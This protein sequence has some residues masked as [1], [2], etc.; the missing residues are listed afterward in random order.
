MRRECIH[1]L[2]IF[3]AA[4]FFLWQGRTFSAPTDGFLSEEVDLEEIIAD[5]PGYFDIE[6]AR[7]SELSLLPCFTEESART[8]INFRDALGDGELFYQ[9]IEDI[10]GLSP[11]QYAVLNHLANTRMDS[12]TPQMSRSLRTGFHHQ[13]DD[14]MLSE[15]RY[16][17]RFRAGEGRKLA[18][19]FLGERDPFE[20][21]ALDLFSANL[22][23]NLEKARTRV[24]IGDYRWGFG[25]RLVLS[26][27]TRNYMN[28]PHIMATEP[29][30]AAN[31]S[32]EETH[33]L[34][35]I[36]IETVREHLSAQVCTS[37]RS[38][39]ATVDESGKA[40]SI[41]ESG[42][43][44]SGTARANLE[45]T[46]TVARLAFH[47][48][49]GVS[50]GVAG[51]ASGYSPPL[52]R[53]SG[54]RYLA[55]PEGSGFNYVSVDGALSRGMTV[56]FF[57]HAR[58]DQ[59]EHA[60]L[61]G[62][63]LHS[64][65]VRGCLAY[66][67]YTEGYWA[68]RSGGISSFGSTSNERGVYSAV[69]AELPFSSKL[70]ASMDLA[71]TLS[72]TYT[73]T[74]PVSRRRVS[75]VLRTRIRRKMAVKMVVRS[76]EDSGGL[77]NHRWNTRTEITRDSGRP[78]LPGVR[79]MLAWSESEGAGGAYGELAVFEKGHIAAFDCACG[80]FDIPTYAARLYRYERDVPGRGMTRAVW[81]RG[82]TVVITL[83]I[84]PFSARYR[85]SDTDQTTRSH[86]VTLQ[87]DMLF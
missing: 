64:G 18:Y 70:V 4:V 14:E 83:R 22:S 67:Y 6:T 82:G 63:E 15:G 40:L 29:R 5:L 11:V 49:K 80:L 2:P 34:R 73:A 38:L 54:E 3:F 72:R 32:F 10:P 16:Y 42:Y 37:I 39:D 78:M 77:E 33:Y 26:R 87:S 43:H 59:H 75:I 48:I 50:L 53:R 41:R 81:G 9:H 31:T 74:M 71:R 56:L 28:G 30:T 65:R 62:L 27:Y 35:G 55:Y 47:G 79:A 46:I 19:T 44:Y 36:F 17:F 52:A 8:I 66:R 68:H 23:L 57:E 7:V 61:G 76:T 21:K 60:T 69:Q 25:Q 45:E 51:I 1:L 12:G 58:S 20:P 84:G 13:P 86:D 85:F 24:L